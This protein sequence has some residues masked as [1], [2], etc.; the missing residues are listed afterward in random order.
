M[1]RAQEQQQRLR[2]LDPVMAEHLGT[3]IARHQR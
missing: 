1:R 3:V 2:D